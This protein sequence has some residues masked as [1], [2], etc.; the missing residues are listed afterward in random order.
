MADIRPNMARLIHLLAA[1][2]IDGAIAYVERERAPAVE[3][4]RLEWGLASEELA[5]MRNFLTSA[6]GP[7]TASTAAT[8]TTIQPVVSRTIDGE[9]LEK[10]EGYREQVLLIA[11]EYTDKNGPRIDLETMERLVRKR[12][13]DFGGITRISTSIANILMK[14]SNYERTANGVFLRKKNSASG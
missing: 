7:Y 8:V 6:V 14:S 4:M 2:D 12:N 13:V 5:A 11:N 9:T 1:K 3:N 10:L